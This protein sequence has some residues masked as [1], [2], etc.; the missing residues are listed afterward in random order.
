MTGNFDLYS[1]NPDGTDL[2]RLTFSADDEYF[3]D[4]SPDR[5]QIAYLRRVG[6]TAKH[7]IWIMNADGTR[8]RRRLEQPADALNLYDATWSP[9]GRTLTFSYQ[10]E[11]GAAGMR[12]ATMG[13][14]NGDPVTLGAEGWKPSWSPD[15]QYL[16]YEKFVS[17]SNRLVTSRPDGTELIERETG[18]DTCCGQ[19]IWSPDGNRILV[20]GYAGSDHVIRFAKLDGNWTQPSMLHP[21]SSLPGLAPDGLRMV[22]A[23]GSDL[24]M[25]F[26]NG[27]EGTVILSGVSG[28]GG[29]SWAR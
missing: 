24:R 4:I 13:A 22:Y 8:P 14:K 26:T 12:I 27:G 29:I 25:F 3:P 2:R 6:N 19:P 21:M 28:V 23:S 15:G 16:A 17:G 5:K 9:D 18:L 20:T 1:V 10:K 7:E 11:A